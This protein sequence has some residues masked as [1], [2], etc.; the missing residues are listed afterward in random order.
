MQDFNLWFFTGVEH[1]LTISAY[2]HILFLV[3]LCTIHSIRHPKTIFIQVTAFTIGHSLT[4]AL[5]VL[6]VFTVPEKLTEFFIA[7]T[8]F[9]TALTSLLVKNSRKEIVLN[10]FLALFF[11]MVHGMGFSFVLRSMLGKEESVVFPL[12]AFNM[13]IEVAQIMVVTIILIIFLLSEVFFKLESKRRIVIVSFLAM[14]AS[15]WIII[16]RIKDLLN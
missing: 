6:S 11:G 14:I 16:E 7:L 8:I 12:F 2:D 1:I 4:L 15:L 10:F 3:A 5:S 13:G 9:L